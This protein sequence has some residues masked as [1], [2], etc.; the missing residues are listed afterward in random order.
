MKGKNIILKTKSSLELLIPHISFDINH[1]LQS[2]GDARLCS[3]NFGTLVRSGNT[4][5]YLHC[6]RGRTCLRR[7]CRSHST[8]GSNVDRL[9]ISR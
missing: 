8:R 7:A 9:R 3:V 4:P 1:G 5:V 2:L 6:Y